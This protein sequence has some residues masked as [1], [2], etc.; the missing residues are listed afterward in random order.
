MR[1]GVAGTCRHFAGP[2]VTSRDR[3]AARRT[4]W[5]FAGP[6]GSSLGRLAVPWAG[7]RAAGP[8]DIFARAA[9]LDLPRAISRTTPLDRPE[10]WGDFVNVSPFY[11]YRYASRGAVFVFHRHHGYIRM[12][13]FEA[14]QSLVSQHPDSLSSSIAA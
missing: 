12:T 8:A 11:E 10:K 7:W 3:L 4:G 13:P 6:A 9:P 14:P 1:K 5:Q 2:A